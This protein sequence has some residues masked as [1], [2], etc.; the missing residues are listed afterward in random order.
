LGAYEYE[1]MHEKIKLLTDPKIKKPVRNGAGINHQNA[2]KI[3]LKSVLKW[4]PLAI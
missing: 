1:A 2:K 4:S 3:V